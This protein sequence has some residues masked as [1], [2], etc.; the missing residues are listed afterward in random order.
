MIHDLF[1]YDYSP[2]LCWLKTNILPSIDNGNILLYSSKYTEGT[3]STKEPCLHKECLS[4]NGYPHFIPPRNIL[5]DEIDAFVN[6]STNNSSKSLVVRFGDTHIDRP[7]PMLSQLRN[8]YLAKAWGAAC[9][10]F[11]I[12]SKLVYGLGDFGDRLYEKLDSYNYGIN[13]KSIIHSYV[14]K[15][16]TNNELII[17]QW[18]KMS[19]EAEQRIRQLLVN[20]GLNQ[21][22]ITLESSIFSN[23]IFF[24]N[25]VKKT[26]SY[27]LVRVD[28]SPKYLLSELLWIEFLHS[29][30]DNILCLITTNQMDHV[31]LVKNKIKTNNMENICDFHVYER[32]KNGFKFEEEE[33]IEIYKHSL[34]QFQ[35]S[36]IWL[37]YS[38]DLFYNLL[39]I[40]CRNNTIID[41]ERII[42]YQ[43]LFRRANIIFKAIHIGNMN[44]YTKTDTQTLLL[45]SLV[46]FK[47]A[48]SCIYKDFSLFFDYLFDIANFVVKNNSANNLTSKVLLTGMRKIGIEF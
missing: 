41:F 42:K 47:Y 30:F 19:C 29:S 35:K 16:I 20:F 4:I 26:K 36:F 48:N 43:E 3:L 45:M 28:G 21:A 39:F 25:V 10:S 33:W 38:H 24:N 18:K 7:N 13:S 44:Q 27:D 6:S 40:G 2:L 32:C 34:Q 23:S 15:G 14:F 46:N 11:N 9:E 31:H 37:P 17:K 22:E 5:I 12:D 1:K 8:L